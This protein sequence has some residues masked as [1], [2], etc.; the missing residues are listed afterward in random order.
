MKLIHEKII[1]AC[2]LALIV[3]PF[4][5][6]PTAWKTVLTVILGLVVAYLGAIIFKSI[7]RHE[8]IAHPEKKTETFTETV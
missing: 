7:R 1:I 8:R 4:M 6:F 5:G 2:G 3:L